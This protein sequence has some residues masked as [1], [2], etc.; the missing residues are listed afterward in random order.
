MSYWWCANCN[1][2]VDDTRVTYQELHDICGHP[3]VVVEPKD[4]MDTLRAENAKLKAGIDRLV[5]AAAKV[6]CHVGD[7]DGLDDMMYDLRQALRPF[8]KESVP[9]NGQRTCDKCGKRM[10]I[11]QFKTHECG[12]ES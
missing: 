8:S 5:E 9:Y 4:E 7:I 1:E 12:G 3:V 2:E 11:A 6:C 10:P